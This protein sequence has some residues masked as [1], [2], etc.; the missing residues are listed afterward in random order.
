MDFFSA[1]SGGGVPILVRFE[2]LRF[3][4]FCFLTENRKPET[5]QTKNGIP[6]PKS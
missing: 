1:L 6:T 3:S 5:T 2:I 4:V